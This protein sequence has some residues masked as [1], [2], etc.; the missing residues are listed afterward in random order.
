MDSSLDETTAELEMD[1][2]SSPAPAPKPEAKTTPT[3]AP[4]PE[5]TPPP[6]APPEPQAPPKES[7]QTAHDL[8]KA[9]THTV[10]QVDLK[11]YEAWVETETKALVADCEIAAEAITDNNS[12][13]Q[14]IA[15]G[16][17]L[18]RKAKTIAETIDEKICAPR[19][20]S[21]QEGND[22]RRK[23]VPALE[24]VFNQVEKKAGGFK[25]EMERKRKAEE[26]ARLAEIKRREEEAARKEAKR[27]AEE[28]RRKAE[29]EAKVLEAKVSHAQEEAIAHDSW[30]N[31]ERERRAKIAADKKER[32][33]KEEDARLAHAEAAVEAGR[34]KRGDA[35][36]ETQT[37]LEPASQEIDAAAKPIPKPAAIPE[38]APIPKPEP[39]PEPEPVAQAPLPVVATPEVPKI[40]GVSH[41]VKWSG[42]VT[43]IKLLIQYMMESG[44]TS[45]RLLQ[46]I[47][48]REQPVLLNQSWVNAKARKLKNQ[49]RIPGIKSVPED[50]TKLRL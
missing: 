35:I 29:H 37:P 47:E 27:I 21:W 3:P 40:E 24:K 8:V 9:P 2:E 38:P 5:P 42:Q 16:L 15:L 23:I 30:V 7:S 36:L 18:K 49:C 28:A 11:T 26:E 50:D 34:E 14:A 43:D 33:D 39:I 17:E 31:A 25:I 48:A 46:E 6:A 44:L 41:R 4:A 32:E 19:R 45:D 22:F 1:A 12:L 10:T 20:A 13:E